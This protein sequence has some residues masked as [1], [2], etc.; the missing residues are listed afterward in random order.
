MD[1]ISV[2]ALIVIMGAVA[3][4]VVIAKQKPAP[5][6]RQ[7]RVEPYSTPIKLSAIDTLLQG[8]TNQTVT[9]LGDIERAV[10]AL[11]ELKEMFQQRP[12]S[13]WEQT[14]SLSKALRLAGGIW[15]FKVPS[16]E[17]GRYRWLKGEEIESMS[18]ENFYKGT[19]AEPGPAR[20]FKMNGQTSPVSYSLPSNLD[21]TLTGTWQV[22]D[23]GRF[24]AQV[25][26]QCEQI[27]DRDVL[28][29]VTSR[30]ENGEKWLLY[31]DARKGEA[32]GTGGLFLL[33]PF[34]PS[35]DISEI[36]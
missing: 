6:R 10:E 24:N 25:K 13:V 33:E 12:N 21:G 28:Y 16:Q 23:I 19:D 20:K 17:S 22:V 26:G 9:L 35:V 36:L 27:S 4:I 11:V 14:G 30:E 3:G 15:I 34:E 5:A 29:F 18:L 31:L 1:V 7:E 32:K 8:A 2:L